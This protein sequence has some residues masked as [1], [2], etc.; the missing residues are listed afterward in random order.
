M[1]SVLIPVYNYDI[2]LLVNT[3]HNQLRDCD[4]KFEIICIDDCSEKSYSLI[5]T[6]INNLSNTS[7]TISNKNIGRIAIR[8][9]LAEQ[10]NYEWLLFLDADVM[11]KMD[12]FISNYTSLLFPNY[13]AIYGGFAYKQ[14]Q[15]KDDYMLRWVYG[16]SNEQVSAS[17]RNQTPYKIVISAN[18]LI[19]KAIFKRLNSQITQRGYGYDNYFGALL[20]SNEQKVFHIDNE[21]YHLG[22]EPNENYLNKIE[23][24][25]DTLLKLESNGDLQQTE[26]TLYNTY[27]LLKKLKINHLFSWIYKVYKNRFKKNLLSSKPKVSVLQFYKLSYICFQDLN[28]L[29][30]I[31]Q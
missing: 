23:Q 12:N 2:R 14:E 10:A 13:D 9:A 17:K 31:S 15:P 16:T 20:K 3:I 29:I 21:V 24:S 26:N 22:L 25:V 5:N 30:L 28:P 7:Y 18:F 19:K 8:Q 4:V 27:K 1:L 11:P 6:E